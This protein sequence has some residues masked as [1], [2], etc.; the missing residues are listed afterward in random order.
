MARVEAR[1]DGLQRIA[2]IGFI[3]GAILLVVFTLLAPRADNPTDAQQVLA[4]L[5]DNKTLSRIVFF[6]GPA[7]GLWSLMIGI[8]GLYR[9]ISEGAGAAWARLG[10]YGVVVGTVGFT[11]GLAF[12]YRSVI[13]S[14]A[15]V[16]DGNVGV[17]AFHVL[18][19]SN[20]FL[21]IFVYWLALVLLGIGL[22]VSGLYPQ[23][24]GWTLIALGAVTAVVS[25]PAGQSLGGGSQ[26]SS[27]IFGAL[28]LLTYL[29]AMVVGGI[30]LRRQMRLM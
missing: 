25:G 12:D 26:F 16:T 15:A 20:N 11:V 5:A 22:V 17:G 6:F 29:W 7:A 27:L 3:L 13:V 24:L 10:F 21:F 28:A 8:T 19:L 9:S 1:G 14:A 23:W 30:I 18:P 4:K 2:S